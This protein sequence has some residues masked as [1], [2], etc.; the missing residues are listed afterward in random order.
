MTYLV[1]ITQRAQRDLADLYDRIHAES[2]PAAGTWYR[3]LKAVILSLEEQPNR[4][5][6][7]RKQQKLRHLL[8]GEKPNVY[9]VL[10]RVVERRKQVEIVL[11]RHGARREPRRAT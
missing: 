2:P 1:N 4:F 6:L 9:R 7:I 11:I 5:P 3:G 8:Y 10:Y